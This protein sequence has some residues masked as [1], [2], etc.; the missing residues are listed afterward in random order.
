VTANLHHAL[1]DYQLEGQ[2]EENVVLISSND[3]SFSH[4]SIVH[5]KRAERGKV[6][7]QL[8]KQKRNC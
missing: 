3:F 2:R 7:K 5:Q 1:G 4:T 8:T 6:N